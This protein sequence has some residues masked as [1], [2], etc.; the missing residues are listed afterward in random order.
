LILAALCSSAA[1][2][3]TLTIS[4]DQ[5]VQT[6]AP[7]ETL[8][9][10]GSI[11]ND[12][13]NTVFLNSDDLTLNDPDLSANDL[14]FTTVPISLAP[15]GQPGD[16]SG[17][18]ELFDLILGSSPLDPT[19]V[20][21]GSYTLVG[22][23]DGDAQD[24]LG[25]ANVNVVG[26]ASLSSAAPEPS[27][28]CLLL[29][30]LLAIVAIAPGRHRNVIAGI[31]L[32]GAL[33]LSTEAQT[34]APDLILRNGRIFTGDSAHTWVEAVSIQSD[35]ILAA[36]TDEHITAT[37]DRHTR[38]I[39]LQGRMAM[40]GINDAHDHVGGARYGVEART[41]E[42]PQADPSLAEL[43]APV[44]P[45]PAFFL[46]EPEAMRSEKAQFP[47]CFTRGKLTQ[48]QP[49]FPPAG[50]MTFRSSPALALSQVKPYGCGPPGTARLES[51]VVV[52][53][54]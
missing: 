29:G 33:T 16:S 1:E 51:R 8:A 20:L 43:T 52:A 25:S 6:G 54:A 42:P 39:D 3:D 37:A 11:F 26:A 32:T 30:G 41:K 40:P 36:G 35:R 9:F 5:P 13:P 27:S 23:V 28:L 2:A 15:Q 10:F 22:G 21:S 24:S 14:F 48:L 7:G 17:D 31:L 50:K 18:I 12:T 44:V 46:F 34:K 49:I 45:D 53:P 4:F 47:V 19:A 38:V